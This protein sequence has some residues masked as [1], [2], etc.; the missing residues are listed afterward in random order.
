MKK[1]FAPFSPGQVDSLNAFQAD[2]ENHPFTCGCRA[3]L[4]A[5]VRGWICPYC[6][7]KQDWAWEWMVDWSW[8]SFAKEALSE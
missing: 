2:S 3:N 6:D 1:V 4:L 7:C 8:K 5:T